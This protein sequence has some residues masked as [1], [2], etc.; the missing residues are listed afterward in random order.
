[1]TDSLCRFVCDFKIHDVSNSNK[2]N[3]S[4]NARIIYNNNNK[5]F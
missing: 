1:M 2:G 3:N 5:Q 4:Y